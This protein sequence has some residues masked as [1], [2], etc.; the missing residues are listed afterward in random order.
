MAKILRTI[1][2]Y[3]V[4]CEECGKVFEDHIEDKKI[5][6]L[7]EANLRRKKREKE[8]LELIKLVTEGKEYTI[9]TIITESDG[10]IGVKELVLREKRGDLLRIS[11]D[12]ERD[13]DDILAW[14]ALNY[15]TLEEQVE[16][17][18]KNGE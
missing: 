4:K 11:P 18:L 15:R 16:R 12:Y 14:I 9:E 6:Y 1:T 10:E 13:S 5:C 3:E 17:K 7:C 8:R 2:F